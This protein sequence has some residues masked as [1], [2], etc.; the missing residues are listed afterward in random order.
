M[1]FHSGTARYVRNTVD[2]RISGV[3][4]ERGSTV[5]PVGETVPP[6]FLTK[7]GVQSRVH[8]ICQLYSVWYVT[9][10]DF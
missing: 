6:G 7:S 4:V 2:D 3:S 9:S 8:A 10:R 5:Q 1:K